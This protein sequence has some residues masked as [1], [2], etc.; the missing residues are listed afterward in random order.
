MNGAPDARGVVA[1]F[2]G[3]LLSDPR[4]RDDPVLGDIAAQCRQPLRVLLV[5]DV[6]AGKST[7]LNALL[8]GHH[9]RTAHRET[10][11][12]VTWFHG[13][14]PEAVRLP[15][16]MHRGVRVGFPL[17]RRLMIADAPGLNTKSE[18]ARHTLR[19]LPGGDLAGAAAAYVFLLLRGRADG[20]AEALGNLTAMTAGPFDLVGNVVAVAGKADEVASDHAEI[21]ER[22]PREARVPI[23][24]VAVH[25]KMAVAAR[26]AEVSAPLLSALA[27][28]RTRPELMA[29]PTL[30]WPH[31]TG[32]LSEAQ[33][34]GLTAALGSPAWL[35]E[36]IRRTADS[37][38][39]E[40]VLRVV[41][42][43]SRIPVLEAVLAD[44]ADDEDLFTATAAVLR[45]RHWAARPG[46][47]DGASVREGLRA[48]QTTAA[49]DRLR[50]RAAARLVRHGQV[51]AELAEE[52][53]DAACELLRSGTCHDPPALAA[54]WASYAAHPLRPTR[55][56][57]VAELI[58]DLARRADTPL[59]QKGAA[60]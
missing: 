59:Q 16:P 55:S 53:R 39:A 48:L 1:G 19:M 5:G 2:C 44:M 51:G 6:S 11:S 36:L 43:M 4:H 27:S 13:L 23:R 38:T 12:T 34:A 52:D 8:A 35:P 41:E 40:D 54:R 45:L 26:V 46:S 18:K 22:V 20:E 28:I 58:A 14:G 47:G 10:T 21:E 57:A 31:L 56:R 33:L 42:E 32:H 24:A 7:L 9:A 50:A 29:R 3:E 15:D 17:A 37:A 30:G 49:F 60:R 25:Q